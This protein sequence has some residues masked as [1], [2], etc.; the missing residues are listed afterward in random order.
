MSLAERWVR[1]YTTVHQ[2]YQ[3][4]GHLTVPRKHVET[5]LLGNDEDEGQERR[6]VPLK[7]GARVG[8]QRSRAASLTRERIEQLSR[9]GMRRA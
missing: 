8:D 1:H 4:E 6:E 9:I 5:V 3:R 7:L 2:Y